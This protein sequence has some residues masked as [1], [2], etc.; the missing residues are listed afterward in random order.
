[1]S[2]VIKISTK[3]A[4]DETTGFGS[5]HAM[6]G[7]RLVNKDGR[8]NIR[9]TGLRFF[10]TLSWYHVLIDIPVLKFLTFIFL[11]FV[12]FNLLFAGIYL[13]IGIENLSG[14]VALTPAQKFLEAFFFSAQTFTT[15][16]YGRINPTGYLTSF[17]AA[18]EA[19]SGLLFFAIATGLFYARFSRPKS[20][21]RFSQN[22][23]VAPYKGGAALMLRMVP[24]KNNSLTDANVTITMAMAVNENGRSVNR[25]YPL[26]LEIPRIN[27]LTLSWTLVHPIDENSPFYNWQEEEFTKNEFEMLVYV[28][29][30]DDMFS[31]TVV[32]R[33]SYTNH[34]VVV[35]AKF[36]PMY[37]RSEKGATTIVELDKLNS[38]EKAEVAIESK[39][40]AIDNRQ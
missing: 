21:I 34:E 3:V 16:G 9:K 28:K 40:S 12:F 13:L 20:F 35:G 11:F 10:E 6:Y 4:T 39:Q 7:G 36:I 27:A 38:F 32:A 17:V 8:P 37:H 23:L 14:M 15:V 22:A 33:T 25:F 29:A 26:T 1:M 2:K 18:L 31:N 24:F 5:N 19:F 30:F